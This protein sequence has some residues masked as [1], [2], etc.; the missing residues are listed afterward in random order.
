LINGRSLEGSATFFL[1]GS[2][3]AFAALMIW[4]PE[5]S[6]GFAIL[7]ALGAALPAAVTELLSKRVDDNLSIPLAAASGAW[8]VS[9]AL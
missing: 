4:H 3:A 7:I 2:G 5:I 8:L 1:V 9:L 6:L